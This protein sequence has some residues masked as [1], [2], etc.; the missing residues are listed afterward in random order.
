MCLLHFNKPAETDNQSEAIEQLRLRLSNI[1]LK[2]GSATAAATSPSANGENGVASADVAPASPDAAADAT[3]ST[4]AAAPQA[5]RKL[6]VELLR[7]TAA[8]AAMVADA[9]EAVAAE[10]GAI[11]SPDARIETVNVSSV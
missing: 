10:V 8:A 9:A 4:A 7:P 2:R 5:G 11:Q 1:S 6:R 3:A